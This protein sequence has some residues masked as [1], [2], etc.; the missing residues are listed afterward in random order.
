MNDAVRQNLI[1]AGCDAELIAAL[2]ACFDNPKQ[3]DRLLAKHRRALLDQ[4]HK[5]EKQISCLDYL[6]Y[7][8]NKENDT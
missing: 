3:R 7:T 5:E 8:M 2:E 1:D 4:I 6:V